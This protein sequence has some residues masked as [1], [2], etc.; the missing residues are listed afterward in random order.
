MQI[1]LKIFSCSV[2]CAIAIKSDKIESL[3][4]PAKTKPKAR[5]E[6]YPMTDVLLFKISFSLY[7]IASLPEAK[8]VKPNPRQ[9]PCMTTS[10]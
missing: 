9:A 8:A 1:D 4:V 10:F 5:A 2:S 6:A 3:L 7:P